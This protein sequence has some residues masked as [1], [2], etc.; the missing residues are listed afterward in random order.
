MSSTSSYDRIDKACHISVILDMTTEEAWVYFKQLYAKEIQEFMIKTAHKQ[1]VPIGEIVAWTAD[2]ELQDTLF[3]THMEWMNDARTVMNRLIIARLKLSQQETP[4]ISVLYNKL[5]ACIK[6]DIK[7]Q[8]HNHPYFANTVSKFQAKYNS[9]RSGSHDLQSL[10]LPQDKI[11]GKVSHAR[12]QSTV[13]KEQLLERIIQLSCDCRVQFSHSVQTIQEQLTSG[14]GSRGLS[15]LLD[16]L[17]THPDNATKGHDSVRNCIFA[18]KNLAYLTLPSYAYEVVLTARDNAASVGTNVFDTMASWLRAKLG[19]EFPSASTI[20]HNVH[21]DHNQGVPLSKTSRMKQRKNKNRV[22][23]DHGSEECESKRSGLALY[24]Q[25]IWSEL[26]VH[27]RFMDW[28]SYYDDRTLGVHMNMSCSSPNFTTGRS[29]RTTEDLHPI[30]H[31]V[32][33]VLE[34]E[35]ELSSC[36]GSGGTIGF[37]FSVMTKCRH[38]KAMGVNHVKK[39]SLTI[40]YNT[41]VY[42]NRKRSQIQYWNTMQCFLLTEGKPHGCSITSLSGFDTLDSVNDTYERDYNLNVSHQVKT[43]IGCNECLQATEASILPS[44]IEGAAHIL[45][46]R[47][48][49]NLRHSTEKLQGVESTLNSIATI[50]DS[51]YKSSSSSSSSSLPLRLVDHGLLALYHMKQGNV[52]NHH[53]SNLD[54]AR[55]ESLYYNEV[56]VSEPNIHYITP[57]TVDLTTTSISSNKRHSICN[58]SQKPVHHL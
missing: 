28:N 33:H 56:L 18:F 49:N 30:Q 16:I 2:H 44:Y 14:G 54:I 4:V 13:S 9:V 48:C 32:R 5:L 19:E 27:A 3:H 23:G 57:T 26:C 6:S 11:K 39:P 25:T 22:D 34:L 1:N 50:H 31:L 47:E 55:G 42:V 58:L 36:S 21:G 53:K 41:I 45:G 7:R 35:D 20:M 43:T 8:E 52:F 40:A 12:A 29:L 37:V 17:S 51:L 24:I 15:F 46:L 38:K 10:I